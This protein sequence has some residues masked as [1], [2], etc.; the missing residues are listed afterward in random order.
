MP[1]PINSQLTQKA[2]PVTLITSS[3]VGVGAL[4]S[5]FMG[6]FSIS[7]FCSVILSLEMSASPLSSGLSGL[8]CS[9]PLLF[10]SGPT[11]CA[12]KTLSDQQQVQKVHI[13]T[14]TAE[15]NRSSS[16][17]SSFLMSMFSNNGG[18]SAWP[19]IFTYIEFNT[20]SMEKLRIPPA[21]LTLT[22]V[23][24]STVICYQSRFI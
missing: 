11:S 4:A 22:D 2:T 3:I 24:H 6:T 19:A 9:G 1:L 17:S 16:S 13:A 14:C 18:G 10:D 20:E 8:S 21:A 7:V 23:S 12:K 15:A 5:V